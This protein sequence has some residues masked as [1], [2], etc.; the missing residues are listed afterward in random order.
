MVA[1]D[2]TS[3]DR[4]RS[5][6]NLPPGYHF[7]PTDAELIVHYLRRKIAGLPPLLPIFID[8]DV[9]GCHPEKITGT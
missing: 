6:L 1:A 5:L 3:G 8:E 9:V 2:A 4:K 7:A